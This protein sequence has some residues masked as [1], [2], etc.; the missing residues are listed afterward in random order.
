MSMQTLQSPATRTPRP[1]TASK[2]TRLR[3]KEIDS[4]LRH[5]AGPVPPAS[6]MAGMLYQLGFGT[7]DAAV[8]QD[9]VALNLTPGVVAVHV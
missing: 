8:E 6:L 2:A 1:T 4:I 9:Y 7:T 3:R 5:W